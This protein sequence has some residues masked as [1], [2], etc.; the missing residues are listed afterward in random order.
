ML[1]QVEFVKY[2]DSN[3][4]GDEGGCQGRIG[5]NSENS[6][7]IGQRGRQGHDGYGVP[8]GVR[9]DGPG[10]SLC[11]APL[12]SLGPVFQDGTGD[13]LNEQRSRVYRTRVGR[14][15]YSEGRS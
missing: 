1:L 7:D 12:E 11:A 2:W 10:F 14:G 13:G 15:S 3:S 4:M 5:V 9:T 8:D 6:F